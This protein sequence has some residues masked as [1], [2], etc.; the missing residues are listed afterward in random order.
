MALLSVA[1]ALA[2]VTQGL[3]PL[4]AE[5]V[6][7]DDASGRV[8]AEDLAAT[9]TQPPFDA[10]AMDGYA[11]RG[12]DL[13][14]LPVTLKLNGESLAGRGFDGS[15]G[16]GEAVRIFT[17]APVPKG[18]DSVVIQEDTEQDGTKVLVKA[19]A[20]GRH[21]RPRGQDFKSGD[22]LL[23]ANTKLNGRSLMVAAAMNHAELPVRRKPKVA[24][25]ATGDEVVPPGSKLAADQI[26]SSVPYGVAAL[27][28]AE[29]GEAMSL[30]IA[31]DDVE[32]LVTLARS[33]S[34]ADILVTIGGAS[35]GERDLVASALRG[36]GLKLEFWKIAMRPGKPMLYGRMGH[37]R[38]LGLP[39]NPVSAIVC[40]RVFLV[41]M[42][43]RLLGLAAEQPTQDAV[44]GE[45][46]EANGP[47]EHYMRAVS[48]WTPT[49]ERV[50]HPLAS[51]DSS[52]VADLA[53]ADCLLVRPVDAPAA[54]KGS[55]VQ[56]L[57]LDG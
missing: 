39:G 14:K 29:G 33:G 44:L 23:A 16:P 36:E 42:L 22:A 17:G 6:G 35:V 49:G 3:A 55:R 19:G 4:E 37:Q 30:G 34:A 21:I 45:A 51:Q 8:L 53:R 38:V 10:S 27:V 1:E 5:M 20:P 12:A 13:A 11:V 40:V 50:V 24:I 2:R 48:D 41:P 26:V 52:L 25:L 28:E 32:S 43:R 15:V 18:A 47:R 9:L 46:L 57:P 54:P 56:I 31:K 7:L